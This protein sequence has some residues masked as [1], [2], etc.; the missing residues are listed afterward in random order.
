MS[1]IDLPI[2]LTQRLSIFTTPLLEMKSDCSARELLF[3]SIEHSKYDKIDE[4]EGERKTRI[5]IGS[6]P[7]S[8]SKV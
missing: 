8:E 1:K 4:E 3:I 2:D 7:F 5:K 6:E